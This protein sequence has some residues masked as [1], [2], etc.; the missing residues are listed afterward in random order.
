MNAE[1]KHEAYCR[2]VRG[3]FR[4]FELNAESTRIV[5]GLYKLASR[6]R[7][8]L[9]D[10]GA[11]SQYQD[12]LRAAVLQAKAAAEKDVEISRLLTEIESAAPGGDV[13]R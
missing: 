9:P 8:I 7:L 1:N 5:N 10:M 4:L 3:F 13:D 11:I 2:V 12:G 6:E